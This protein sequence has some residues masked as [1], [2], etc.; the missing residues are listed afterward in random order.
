M[1]LVLEDVRR[2]S[3]ASGFPEETIEKSLRL[4][5]VLQGLAGHRGLE[6]KFVLKGGTAL[7]L[8]LLR[9][10]RLS[11]DIDLNYVGRADR[12]TMVAERPALEA[13]VE[14]ICRRE[15]FQP[16]R[17]PDS[18]AGGK[19]RMA[20]TDVRGRNSHLAVDLNFMLRV[21]LWPPERLD[22]Q[23][24]GD[25]RATGIPVVERHELAGAKFVALLARHASRD[26]FD[27]VELL[28]RSDWDWDRLRLAFLAYGAWNRRDWREVA[29]EDIQFDK[30]EIH[31]NLLPVL[32][33]GSVPD[34]PDLLAWS[35]ELVDECRERMAGLLPLSPEHRAFLDRLNDQGEI[36]PELVTS[37]T[38]MRELL[39]THPMM[40]WKAANVRAFRG[41]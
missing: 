31:S 21:P 39:S 12:D 3:A 2:I 11:V 20:Y 38:R 23:V 14:G 5:S 36:A 17:T 19:W 41:L 10:P 28:R 25:A 30:Q 13:A 6:G 8:F 29:V 34:K 15:G 27:A 18:H 32:A 4:L 24:L 33:R 26:L 40:S 35:Q 37:D 22:S 1:R 7:N 9:L 16:R